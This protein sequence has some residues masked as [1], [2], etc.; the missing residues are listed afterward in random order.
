MAGSRQ[1]DLNDLHLHAASG[2]VPPS[3]GPECDSTYPLR[4]Y[5]RDLRLW[6]FASDVELV[7]QAPLAC[8]R[9]TGQAKELVRELD[10]ATL[11]HGRQLQDGTRQTGIQFL[12]G[13]LETRYGVLAQELQIHVLRELLHFSRK[14]QESIDESLS[15]FGILIH[16][17]NEGAGVDLQPAVQTWILL[18]GLSIPPKEWP[19]VLHL[20]AGALPDTPDQFGVLCNYLKR[21]GH[22]IESG[23]HTDPAKQFRQSYFIG[24]GTDAHNGFQDSF[25]NFPAFN[26]DFSS[27]GGIT[28]YDDDGFSEAS[29]GLSNDDEPIN[30]DDVR[31][32]DYNIAGEQLYFEYRTAKRRWRKWQGQPRRKR[33]FFRHGTRR[34]GSGKGRRLKGNSGFGNSYLSNLAPECQPYILDSVWPDSPQVFL[35]SA[36]LASVTDVQQVFFKGNGKGGKGARR[37]G[38]PLGRDGTQLKCSICNSTEH[39]RA[40]CPQRGPSS[41]GKGAGKGSSS[42]TFAASS[43]AWPLSSP[44]SSSA[45]QASASSNASNPPAWSSQARQWPIYFANQPPQTPSDSGWGDTPVYEFFIDGK[46][47]QVKISEAPEPDKSPSESRVSSEPQ[48]KTKYM[49]FPCWPEL[50]YHSNVRLK[51]RE[52]LLVDIGAVHNLCGSEWAGRMQKLAE[53]AGQ[54]CT[55][56]N[57]EHGVALE[58]VGKG[59]NAANTEV[60]MPILLETGDSGE[61]KALTVDGP[62]PAL[63]GLDALERYS[64]LVCTATKR[65]IM[66]GAGGYKIVLSPGSKIYKL[67]KAET[68]HLM[69]PC[70]EWKNHPMT[71]SSGKV[72]HL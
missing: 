1:A 26:A 54:G 3:W 42:S 14:P 49:M 39:F 30:F 61:Y 5:L 72:L 38:N 51:D 59:S 10:P 35:V 23:S 31:E 15:R 71:K 45:Y 70:S 66:P 12:V 55:Y 20:T 47:E 8:L 50:V 40:V 27:D 62:L 63:L 2:K 28:E 53:A 11:A 44:T 41:G 21:R 17:A 58:G 57:L 36:E 64:A 29:S 68:G 37:G 6:S 43:S 33:R 52:A 7:R 65:L 32:I 9:L 18:N 22:L 4:T 16:K 24:D 13:T 25:A 56:R 19:Q 48:S 34:K 60:T 46:V 69:L 67:Y